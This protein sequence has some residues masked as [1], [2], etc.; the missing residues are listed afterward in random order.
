MTIS[1]GLLSAAVVLLPLLLN[2]RLWRRDRKRIRTLRAASREASPAI[3]LTSDP[4]ERVS[5]L[6]PA[7]NAES[8]LR[9]CVEAILRLPYPDFEVVLCAGGSD[10]SWQIAS[11]FRDPRVICLEQ[12]PGD[13]KQKSLRR[14]LERATGEIIYLLDADC[15]ITT[16]AFARTLGPILSHKEQAVT[17]GLHTPF[18]E[19]L[20]IPFVV[21]QC[22]C[23]DYALLYQP[24]YR[25]GLQGRNCAIRRTALEQAGAFDTDVRTGTDYDLAKRLVRQGT[26]IRHEVDASFPTLFHTQVG[27][28]WRQ[29]ARFLRNVAIHGFYYGSYR[30]VASSLG[31]SLVG[32]AM[33]ALPC[34]ALVLACFVGGASNIVRMLAAV[35]ALGILYAFFSRLRYLKVAN[36]WLGVR[37]PRRVYA[38]LPVFLLIDFVA[39]AMPLAQYPFASLRKRW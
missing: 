23:L 34:G 35:W 26:R 7:W 13:G 36:A 9:A 17:G 27:A 25:P 28:Y 32:F 8:T 12:R 19:Q 6:V 1:S 10:R 31:T 33:L 22:A 37:I 15:L 29:Q 39:W 5:F 38:L 14:C 21:S 11:Q 18:P 20:N 24:D 30:E 3:E 2:L 16:A 4:V